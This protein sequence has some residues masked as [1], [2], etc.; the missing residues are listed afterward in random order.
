VITRIISGGQTGADRAGLDYAIANG[1]PQGGSCPLGRRAEDGVVPA[2]YQLTELTSSG[3]GARTLQNVIDSDGTAIFTVAT[4]LTGGSL[5]TWKMAR[6]ANRHRTHV[7]AWIGTT[8]RGVADA[9]RNLRHWLVQH[10]VGVL[11]IAGSRASK[12]PTV[13]DWTM[14]VLTRAGVGL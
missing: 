5:L 10:Q 7:T 1:I 12:E 9:A 8:D 6:D 3:Y 2:H 14:A 11:N 13:H 4:A